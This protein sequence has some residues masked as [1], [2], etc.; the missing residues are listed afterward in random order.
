LEQN[1]KCRDLLH[2]LAASLEE[3]LADLSIKNRRPEQDAPRLRVKPTA[4]KSKAKKEKVADSWEDDLSSGS[5]TETE[6]EQV[7]T[8]SA[9][10]TPST[11]NSE[12]P[13]APPPTP[14]SPQEGLPQK[15]TWD[16]GVHP[17]PY[18]ANPSAT[19]ASG[20][21]SGLPRA[22]PEKQTAVANRLIAGALGI[23]APKRTEEQRAYDRAIK[24]NEIRRRN[25]AKEE[26]AKAKQEE[27]RVKAAV[28]SG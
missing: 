28:W 24:E 16:A 15:Q 4:V 3:S 2:L 20:R 6:R 10:I 9:T 5:D 8:A 12:E 7:P 19:S 11:S 1:F 13:L 18:S 27:E 14:V 25:R 21:S 17:N 23:R 26:E 22:R